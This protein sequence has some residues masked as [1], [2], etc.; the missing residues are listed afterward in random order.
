MGMMY[1]W[2]LTATTTAQ[3]QG[4]V[5]QDTDTLIVARTVQENQTVC[6]PFAML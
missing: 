5:V 6:I 3:P 4:A 1:I 2:I